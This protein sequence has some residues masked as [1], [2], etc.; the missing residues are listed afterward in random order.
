MS[1]SAVSEINVEQQLQIIVGNLEH[2]RKLPSLRQLSENVGVSVPVIDRYL[3][4]MAAAGQILIKPRSGAYK[5][6]PIRRRI[7][8]LSMNIHSFNGDFNFQYY[9]ISAMV[10]QLLCG[11]RQVRIHDLSRDCSS[12]KLGGIGN[13]DNSIIITFGIQQEQF[14]ILDF[15]AE[16]EV[17][18]IHVL[19]NYPGELTPSIKIDDAGLV[20][21]Q[22]EF[23]REH[24]YRRI[25]YFHAAGNAIGYSR[26]WTERLK[27][28]YRLAVEMELELKPEYIF[29]VGSRGE[30]M[31]EGVE[32]LKASKVPPEA[33]IIYDHLA[34]PL[35]NSLRAN[36]MEPGRDIAV[37]GTDDMPW[38]K[39]M[40]PPLS[41]TRICLDSLNDILQH[42]ITALEAGEK[43]GT[44][45]LKID[46]IKRATF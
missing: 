2:G 11:E 4:K 9:F 42:T 24:G 1:Q 35:Y 39:M 19:P 7:E 37:L 30:Y 20:K 5:A 44:S 23:L 16:R 45:Y 12:I 29:D 33:V 36:G 13:P 3:S 17:P 22:I 32:R 8:I 43:P 25:A 15:L 18:M 26:A 27:A 21:T 40:T 6:M 46:K 14:Q 41:S 10:N 34:H 31:A 28:F 38:N